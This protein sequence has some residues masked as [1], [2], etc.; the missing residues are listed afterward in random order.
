MLPNNERSECLDWLKR[1]E[2]THLVYTLNEAEV[3]YEIVKG[4]YKG[5]RITA[6]L[7]R[8]ENDPDLVF[9]CTIQ[10][11]WVSLGSVLEAIRAQRASLN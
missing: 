11:G 9:V 3:K 8:Q 1:G 10:R 5:V 4:E 7:V 2:F 6:S